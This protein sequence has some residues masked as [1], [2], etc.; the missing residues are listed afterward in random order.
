MALT[1]AHNQQIADRVRETLA[2]RRISR[3]TL[4]V[5]ARISVSTLEKGAGRGSAPFSLA[6]V[7]RL[8]QALGISCCGPHRTGRRDHCTTGIRSYARSAVS[9]LEGAYLTLRPS[10]EVT[11]SIHAYCTTT[12]PGTMACT[13]CSSVRENVSTPQNSQAGRVCLPS[14]TGKIY[15]EHFTAGQGW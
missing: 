10:F 12:L 5:D 2:R 14:L 3:K 13:A 15:L 11:G 1:A 8:E 9:W 6:S 7:M 4:A